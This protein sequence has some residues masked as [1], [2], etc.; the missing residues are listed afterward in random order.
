MESRQQRD[1][2]KALTIAADCVCPNTAIQIK[3]H[4]DL[5]FMWKII[6]WVTLII[7]FGKVKMTNFA[8]VLGSSMYVRNKSTIQ[9]ELVIHEAVHMRQRESGKLLW[10]FNYL[11]FLPTF[12]TMRSRYEGDAYAV[13]S[14]IDALYRISLRPSAKNGVIRSN[15][16]SQCR[17]MAMSNVNYYVKFAR[18]F[19]YF[20][21]AIRKKAYRNLMIQH[22]DAAL[23]LIYGIENGNDKLSVNQILENQRF[24]DQTNVHEV[25]TRFF[26]VK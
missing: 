24:L 20:F 13:S 5:G 19:A 25:A 18:S 23:N 10:Y 21:M 4:E 9:P 7:T 8:F 11:F 6:Y 12:F 17:R 1:V 15:L 26:S 22:V 3:K 16:Y 2:R 14:V